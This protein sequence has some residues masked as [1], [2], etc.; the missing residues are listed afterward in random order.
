MSIALWA[1]G[2][3]VHRCAGWRLPAGT[4][5]DRPA[6]G[7]PVVLSH[8]TAAALWGLDLL[9]PPPRPHVTVPRASSRLRV[10]GATVHRAD[11]ADDEV[12]EHAGRVVTTVLRTTCDL[13]RRLPLPE[14][15]AV[16]DSALRQRLV[17]LRDVQRCAGR[18]AGPGS[19]R[20]RRAISLA[21]PRSESFLESYCRGV[22]CAAGL[23]PPATQY[24]VRRTGMLIA[25]VDVAWP[26]VRLAVEV[27]GFAF[28]ADRDA[29]RRDRRR[30]NALQLEGWT[31]LRFSWEDVVDRPDYVVRMVRA[32]LGP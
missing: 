18:A 21:D 4:T 15:L 22:L 24:E 7:T 28:H 26:A 9:R 10:P 3:A 19:A 25:R 30:L 1:W 6:M 8:E 2:L 16:L 27:D 23:R 12:V 11:L 13:A 17:R 32:A 5:G 14:A 31:V 29:Y 20:L